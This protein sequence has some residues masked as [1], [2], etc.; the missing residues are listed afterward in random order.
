MN[1]IQIVVTGRVQGVSFRAYTKQK[2]EELG[3]TGTVRN[4]Q[5]GSV[6]IIACGPDASLAALELWA[7]KSPKLARVD[8]LKVQRLPSS[9]YNGFNILK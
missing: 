2:A 3:L 1:C 5:D 4:L 7:S 6:E 8:N 9:P